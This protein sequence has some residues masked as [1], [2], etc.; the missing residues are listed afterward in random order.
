M[1]VEQVYEIV[2]EAT[3]QYLGEESVLQQD[4]SNIVDIG[5]EV[6]SATDVDNYV[7]TLVDRIGKVIFVSRPYSGNVPS[8]MM[9]SFEY[10]AVVE[11]ISADLPEA[12]ENESWELEDGKS[13][14][15]NIFYQPK[16][17]ANFFNSKVTFEVPM[18]FTERQVKE[19]FTS[20]NEVNAFLTML[21]NSVDKALTVKMDSLIMGTINAMTAET[22]E[23]D[24]QGDYSQTSLKAVNLLKLFNDK[25]GQT[26]KAE[27]ALMNP[28]F[29][30]FASM[31]MALYIDRLGK[32]SRLFNIGGK[33]RFTSK[34][35]L[36]IVMLSDF[37]AAAN[38]YLQ[39]EVFHNEFTALPE[40]DTV[41]YWQGSGTDYAFDSISRINVK[42]ANDSD[43]EASGIL[44][45]MF[46]RESCGVTNLD[47]RVTT[48]HNPRAEFFTNWYKFD[49]GYFNDFNE[50]FVV[51]FVGDAK[52][53]KPKPADPPEEPTN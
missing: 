36:H 21:Y 30:R 17:S 27:N 37:K 20:A 46:D 48:N 12:S 11:K 42:T 32:L 1:N 52:E 29:I 8:I 4:L 2:N 28:E 18:S 41:P 35:M 50:N 43:V 34:D 33:D 7:K 47:R 15:P 49:A 9:D 16:V 24:L 10:G 44:A 5:K 14:D 26:L 53:E 22:L 40:A 51:F 13:Y 38:S 45:I 19:S 6:F 25:F 31:Q 3:K 39:S 23:N